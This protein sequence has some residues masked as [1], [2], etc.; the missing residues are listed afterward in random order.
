MWDT[1]T[2]KPV[3]SFTGA[4][5]VFASD[6]RTLPFGYGGDT[7]LLDAETGRV[8]AT[9]P[10]T[11]G[12]SLAILSPDRHRI[13]VSEQVGTANVVVVYDLTTMQ[14][15]GAP[16][17]L[18][19]TAAYPVGFLPDGR[20]VTSGQTEAGIWTLGQHLPPLATEMNTE[21]HQGFLAGSKGSE[22]MFVPGTTHTILTLSGFRGRS[23]TRRCCTTPQP[24]ASLAPCSTA[25]FRAWS[26]SAQTD[27]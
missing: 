6:G 4:I 21:K 5:G 7:V 19:G 15:V 10:N 23:L 26:L 20:L 3:L 11:G 17:R 1:R 18:H 9:V 13:A 25:P 24:D 8:Q 12:K 27:D 22:P 16:L 14:P 2:N